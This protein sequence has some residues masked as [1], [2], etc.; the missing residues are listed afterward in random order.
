VAQLSAHL[1]YTRRLRSVVTLFGVLALTAAAPVR[2]GF[3]DKIEKS[4][5]RQAARALES[6]YGVIDDGPF[7]AW[8]RDLGDGLAATSPR[9]GVRYVFKVLDTDDVNAAACPDGHIYV[10]KGMI[11]YVDS[12]DQLA[13]V[14]G[15]EIG[16]VV[17]RHSLHGFKKQFWA[18]LA[19]LVVDMPAAAL[20]GGR[21]ASNLYFLRHSRKDEFDADRKGAG[22]AFAA[23]YDAPQVLDFFG[24]LGEG[25]KPRSKIDSYFATHPPSATRRERLSALPEVAAADA[26]TLIRIGEGLTN[27][28]LYGQAIVRYQAAAHLAPERADLHLRLGAA[29]AAVGESERARQAYRQA[30]ELAP[31]DPEPEA[32]LAA[33]PAEA[34][35][36]A[37][38]QVDP[39]RLAQVRDELTR[40]AT[41]MRQLGFGEET[42]EDAEEGDTEI[43]AEP[44]ALASEDPTLAIIARRAWT[45]RQRGDRIQADYKELSRRIGQTA[46]SLADASM[47]GYG[48]ET[49]RAIERAAHILLNLDRAAGRLSEAADSPEKTGDHCL[50][51]A[52]ELAKRLGDPDARDRAGLLAAAERYLAAQP[53]RWDDVNK[54]TRIAADAIKRALEAARFL[55]DGAEALGFW[56]PGGIT[57]VARAHAAEFDLDRAEKATASAAG[58]AI[59]AAAIEIPAGLDRA[60]WDLTLCTYSIPAGRQTQFD[61]LAAD[62]LATT[63]QAFAAARQERGSYGEAVLAL[64]VPPPREEAEPDPE[65]RP[66]LVPLES[67]R[68]LLA[69]LTKDIDREL[70]AA[71]EWSAAPQA[72]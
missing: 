14:I 59:K 11:D 67:A 57:G 65:A 61:A 29:W 34:P 12:S 44:A 8:L 40:L 33:L 1:R 16:H 9:K 20:A 51:V 35:T 32:A 45:A 49:Q 41:A 68:L 50:A 3:D 52:E 60:T 66:D 55:R 47:F 71:E 69:L 6:T 72:Q 54:S 27:R 39:A 36:P 23:G 22:Y 46:Q 70:A 37:E 56:V 42:T 62:Y 24:R 25:E 43:P 21:L 17:G 28:S 63:P 18:E 53:Q 13:C 4:L 2:A 30:A 19:F 64:A 7:Q 38:P 5:G 15:H 58:S 48:W 26:D 31:H 10:T